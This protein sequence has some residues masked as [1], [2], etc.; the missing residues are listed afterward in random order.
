MTP[1]QNGCNAEAN[2]R[3]T[4]AVAHMQRRIILPLFPQLVDNIWLVDSARFRVCT[5]Q[6]D[7]VVTV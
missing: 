6:K 1:S 5:M 2:S 4:V 3:D 7:S